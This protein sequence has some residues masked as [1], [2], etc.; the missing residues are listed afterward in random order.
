MSLSLAP[1]LDRKGKILVTEDRYGFAKGRF[2]PK[3]S[4][5]INLI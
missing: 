3:R 1:S 2:A 4:C 5:H